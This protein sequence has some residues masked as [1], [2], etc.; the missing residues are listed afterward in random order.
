MLT[1][2]QSWRR[3]KSSRAKQRQ[4]HDEE[5]YSE[6]SLTV[7]TS[8]K[9]ENNLI[10][11]CRPVVKLIQDQSTA[12]S[13][14][15]SPSE[16]KK[17]RFSSVIRVCL[18]PCRSDFISDFHDLFW[19][20]EDYQS[21][22]EDAVR[23]LRAH[24]LTN[25]T[26]VKEAI[27]DLYQPNAADH[28]ASKTFLTHVDSMAQLKLA[29]FQ[30]NSAEDL[31]TLQ[32]TPFVELGSPAGSILLTATNNSSSDKAYT[33][34]SSESSDNASHAETWTSTSPPAETVA[35]SNSSS[36]QSAAAAPIEG[37]VSRGSL[38]SQVTAPHINAIT[39]MR[40]GSIRKDNVINNSNASTASQECKTNASPA[41][42]HNEVTAPDEEEVERESLL[43]QTK[44]TSNDAISPLLLQSPISALLPTIT[45]Q[46]V[47]I[48]SRTTELIPTQAAGS[49]MTGP[50][51]CVTPRSESNFKSS[52][53]LRIILMEDSPASSISSFETP[54][55]IYGQ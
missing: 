54:M 24:W 11:S 18:V 4:K 23:E 17:V 13:T 14:T 15:D 7:H 3:L 38:L 33:C 12:A 16:R 36:N 2:A 10:S 25:R 50:V 53:G 42:A 40:R 31:T 34:N 44:N 8:Q 32:T 37:P 27:I 19:M 5:Y 39:P 47:P 29:A 28:A 51:S 22:K 30:I 35:D 48:V 49:I 20:R 26:T 9:E 43:A 55:L 41:S 52:D 21:F 46:T 45:S 6:C 1:N